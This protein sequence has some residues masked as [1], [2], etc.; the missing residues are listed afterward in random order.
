MTASRGGQPVIRTHEPMSVMADRPD[1]N[2][3]SRRPRPL[4]QILPFRGDANVGREMQAAW[5]FFC[6]DLDRPWS[7]RTVSAVLANGPSHAIASSAGRLTPI[8]G[9]RAKTLCRADGGWRAATARARFGSWRACRGVVRAAAACCVGDVG[10]S[11]ADGD[12]GGAGALDRY[13][14]AHRS[15]QARDVPRGGSRAPRLA[16]GFS[17]QGRQAGARQGEAFFCGHDPRAR[18]P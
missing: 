16:T 1:G 4:D 14:S 6:R 12:I 11:P 9:C 2:A 8:R 5:H 15:Q 7:D 17:S 18:P 13:C 3:A 10:I